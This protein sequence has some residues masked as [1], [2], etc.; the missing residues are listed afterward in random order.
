MRAYLA[1][2]S[3]SDCPIGDI[4][5]SYS[6]ARIPLTQ[7]A[8][9]P[10]EERLYQPH[11]AADELFYSHDREVLIEG[12]AGTG[13]TRAICE[14]CHL[15]CQEVPGVRIL[16]VR[17]TRVS[18]TESVLVTFEEKVLPPNDPLTSGP[19]R[20]GRHAY[21]YPNGSEII[22]GGLD[23]PDRIMSTE[24]DIICVF[25]ATETDLRAWEQLITRGRNNVLPWQQ[26]IAD[27]N[28]S[29]QR[30]WLI[31]RARG[32]SMR[33]MQSKHADNPSL[34]DAYLSDLANNLTGHRRARLYE[35]LWVAAEGLV[36]PNADQCFEPHH[37]APRGI[38]V[39]GMDFGW[40]NPFCALGA[41]RYKHDDGYWHLYVWYERYKSEC[42]IL[43]H[44]EALPKGIVWY[45]DPSAPEQIH[46]LNTAG[47]RTRGAINDIL[48]GVNAVN[49][50]VDTGTL[51]IS[52]RCSA[53]R[54]ELNAYH[55]PEDKM[56]EKPV[57]EFNHACDALRYLVVG[58]D[59]GK[60]AA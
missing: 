5:D 45:A 30:H 38:L 32:E 6:L 37:D 52:E 35:G 19:H 34:T 56:S 18:M 16:W 14:K 10:K 23:N 48:L 46:E 17:Q 55:Y 28:P 44:C 21:K 59:R 36:Y 15:I 49:A 25:E 22:I 33:H 51:H 29:H 20:Y 41:T 50:R 54:A 24:Y 1:R 3:D 27:C 43:K 12:P 60:V 9:I 42:T 11:G 58:V 4:G 2:A 8:D 7:V 26:Q 53:L 31:M 39:G 13:K 40:N 47:H 57:D